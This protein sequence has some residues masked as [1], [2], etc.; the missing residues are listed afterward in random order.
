MIRVA[1]ARTPRQATP[2][3]GTYWGDAEDEAGMEMFVNVKMALGG[4]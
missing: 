3:S 1:V 4:T 2:L